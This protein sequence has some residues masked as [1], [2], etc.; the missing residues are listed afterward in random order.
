[1]RPWK[2]ICCP[3]DFSDPSRRAL[4]EAGY[5]AAALDGEL[6]VIH[7]HEPDPA[8]VETLRPPLAEQASLRPGLERRLQ[9][10]AQEAGPAAR[11]CASRVLVGNP[12]L[13][14]LRFVQA[15][16]V[17][18]LVMGTHGRKGL[19]HMLLGS[20]AERVIRD[21]PCPVLVVRG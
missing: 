2:K 3:V 17:D 20:V 7:V 9:A 8:P 18:V 5:L 4:A 12:T 11:P 6:T 13:E 16:G 19:R 21:A 15:E 14:I 10:W 1:M